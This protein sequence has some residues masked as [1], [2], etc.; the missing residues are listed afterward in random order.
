MDVAA[1]DGSLDLTLSASHTIGEFLLPDWLAEFRRDRRHP[2]A[3]GDVNSL[4]VIDA[5][6]ENRSEIGFVEGLQ[7]PDG[8]Q[9]L[10]V[11]RDEIVVV[12]AAEHPWAHRRSITAQELTTEAY[13]TREA[14][15]GTRAVAT[16]AL[17]A[18]VSTWPPRYRR[19]MRRASN[20]HSP[21]VAL[22]SHRG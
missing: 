8:V 10:T 17:A 16:A 15:S 12:V 19:P 21:A 2:P 6:R 22:P 13:L 1:A 7:A 4:G 9:T 11:A 3:A 20:A 5:V 14:A 18:V